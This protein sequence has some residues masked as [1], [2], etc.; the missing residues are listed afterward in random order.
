MLDYDARSRYKI[1]DSMIDEVYPLLDV[2]GDQAEELEAEVTWR[3]RAG[4]GVCRIFASRQ[5]LPDEMATYVMSIYRAGDRVEGA[6]GRARAY[7][8]QAEEARALPA[9]LHVECA[10]AAPGA[11]PGALAHRQA[12]HRAPRAPRAREMA[13]D[14]S[15]A[16]AVR[17]CSV[18]L[19]RAPALALAFPRFLVGGV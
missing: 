17:W 2:Y 14:L 3:R 9:A 16:W 1:I 13:V 19:T 15:R 8:L 6:D 10:R 4:M 7:E 5:A 12:C 11:S 18:S